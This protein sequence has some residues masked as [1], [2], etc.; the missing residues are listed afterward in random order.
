MAKYHSG[1][2]KF[3]IDKTDG[4]VLTNGLTAHITRFGD[5]EVTKESIDATP[6]GS[7]VETY[8]QGVIARRAPLTFG[9]FYDDGAEPAPD[10]VLNINTITHAATRS[11][12]ITLGAK[13]VSGECWIESYKRTFDVGTYHGYECT[14]RFTGAVTES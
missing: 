10:A 13:K 7:T 14:I 9:G 8:L 12:E 11:Y 4:G 6:L 2:F 3:E 1:N 5:L